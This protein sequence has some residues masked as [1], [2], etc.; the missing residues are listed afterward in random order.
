MRVLPT[1]FLSLFLFM[2]ACSTSETEP[3]PTDLTL[4]QILER[5]RDAMSEVTAYKTIGEFAWIY[6]GVDGYTVSG[7]LNTAWQAP[8][9]FISTQERLEPQESEL[10]VQTAE[11]RHVRGRTFVLFDTSH[12]WQEAPRIQGQ[13]PQPIPHREI[14]DSIPWSISPATLQFESRGELNLAI[15]GFVRVGISASGH[16]FDRFETLVV[17]TVTWRFVEHSTREVIESSVLGTSKGRQQKSRPK[18][19]QDYTSTY[20]DNNVPNVIEAPIP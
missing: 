2:V 19:G 17:D 6:D 14:I 9:D 18:S 7:N 10:D 3:D 12:E 8:N 4:D 13:G 11:F 15:I 16:H 1:I 20:Y 5:T